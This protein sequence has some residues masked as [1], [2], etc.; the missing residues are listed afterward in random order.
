MSGRA[1]VGTVL[2]VG[3]WVSQD[4]P[5]S[6]RLWLLIL[7]DLFRLEPSRPE[8]NLAALRAVTQSA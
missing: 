5:S 8:R 3:Q 4:M 6:S 1:G 7:V 2:T